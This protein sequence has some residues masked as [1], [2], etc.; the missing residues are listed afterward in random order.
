MERGLAQW[1][2]QVRRLPLRPTHETGGAPEDRGW[3]AGL[4]EA[5][6]EL[7]R[8]TGVSPG[9]ARAFDGEWTAATRGGLVLAPGLPVAV[10]PTEQE[11]P[12]AVYEVDAEGR[13][14]RESAGTASVFLEWSRCEGRA[15]AVDLMWFDDLSR[16]VVHGGTLVVD[17]L[18]SRMTLPAHREDLE[19]ILIRGRRLDPAILAGLPASPGTGASVVCTGR[20]VAAGHPLVAPER[21][22]AARLDLEGV[23]RRGDEITARGPGGEEIRFEVRREHAD[24]W[25]IAVEGD[26]RPFA[27]VSVR[28]KGAADLIEGV[29][30]EGAVRPLAPGVRTRLAFDLQA[31]LIAAQNS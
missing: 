6:G 21:V 30:R 8:L 19:G 10:G 26:L 17:D 5:A 24:G 18:V 20:P 25:E 13:V 11:A 23:A 14:V 16:W 9:P 15:P 22:V 12:D 1:L 31:D 29:L 3:F 27:G 28:R 7:R 2:D 4:E